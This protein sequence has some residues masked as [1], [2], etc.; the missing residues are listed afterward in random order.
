MLYARYRYKL[1]RIPRLSGILTTNS[2]IEKLLHINVVLSE[3]VPTFT[4]RRQIPATVFGV[5][6][7]KEQ[8]LRARQRC[9]HK[10]MSC[11]LV[12]FRRLYYIRMYK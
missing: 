8:Q 11:N 6:K 4:G 1:P 2:V 9:Y 5:F 7:R 3:C 12:F 10:L